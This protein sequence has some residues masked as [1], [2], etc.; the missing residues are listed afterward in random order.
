VYFERKK[1][2]SYA[3]T[4]AVVCLMTGKSVTAYSSEL[5]EG[6]ITTTETTR[7]LP[8]EV[9]TALAFMV[10]IYQVNDFSSNFEFCWRMG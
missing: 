1:T 5:A 10:G 9:A 4:F 3:G 8:M 6:N 7:Y 2:F